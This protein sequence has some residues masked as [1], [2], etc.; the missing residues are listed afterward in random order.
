MTAARYRVC[1][2]LLALCLLCGLFGC[3]TGKDPAPAGEGTNEPPVEGTTAPSDDLP[4]LARDGEFLCRVLYPRQ[5]ADWEQETAEELCETLRSL[6]KGEPEVLSDVAPYQADTLDIY[7]GNTQYPESVLAVE[8]LGYGDYTV[9]LAG[10]KIVIA[11]SQKTLLKTAVREFLAAVRSVSAD[12]VVRVPRDCSATVTAVPLLNAVPKIGARIKSY[13]IREN[14]FYTMVSE[15]AQESLYADYL[16]RLEKAGFSRFAER[17]VA[18]NR[19]ATYQNA[20]AVVQVSFVPFKKALHVTVDAAGSTALPPAPTSFERVCAT[21]MSL[22]GCSATAKSDNGQSLFFR[23]ADG[24]F[25]VWDGGGNDPAQDAANLYEKMRASADAAG[26]EK[27]VVAGWFLTHCH[28]DHALTYQQF[29]R[30]YTDRVE[31]DALIFCPNTSE[32]GP[33]VSDG[34]AHEINTLSLT[35]SRLPEAEV[36][37]ARAGQQFTFSDVTVNVLYTLDVMMPYSFTDYNNSSVVC[38]VTAGEKKVL[39]TG[40]CATDGMNY[41]A[42][43]YGEALRCDYLQ[44]PH[45][46]A[47]PGGTIKAYQII[48][49]AN[50]LWTAGPLTYNSVTSDAYNGSNINRY[51]L[52][53]MG[54]K[55]HLFLAGSLGEITTISF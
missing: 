8:Q 4:V 48:Q 16:S 43:V 49:P 18:G 26:V 45:H 33:A 40:D 55:D 5:G 52:E 47:I 42:N 27:V 31:I 15:N 37:I 53:T 44:V 23:L 34:L 46:G 39:I 36:I 20:E 12:G 17:T 50:L 21:Q 35:K 1:A 41:L 38:M 11:A 28:S 14:E 2:A 29:C 10:N 3:G 6:S 25:L 32:Y 24:R 22:L 13:G 9:R 7:I 51:L 30:N 19:F 54:L